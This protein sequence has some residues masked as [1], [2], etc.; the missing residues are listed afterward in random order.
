M[1]NANYWYQGRLT[2]AEWKLLERYPLEALDGY[3][4]SQKAI[5]LTWLHF[6]RNSG[7]D[8]SDA[9]RHFMWAGLMTRELGVSLARQFS[10]AHEDLHN[11]SKKEM[12]S[13]EMDRYNNGKG[14]Q[15][16]LALE[17]QGKASTGNLVDRALESL[18]N[19]ELDVIRKKGGPVHPGH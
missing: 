17:S 5:A 19:E 15:A 13:S 2:P 1:R 4:Q 14:I 10:D 12:R 11:P 18:K 7:D 3:V 16:E 9:F 6:A 8:E